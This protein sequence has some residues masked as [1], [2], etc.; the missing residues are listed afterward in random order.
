MVE[1]TKT[2]LVG[3]SK[4]ASASNNDSRGV[5]GNV[6]GEHG[7]EQNLRSFDHSPRQNASPHYI[8]P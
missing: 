1:K 7:I 2:I 4:H 3:T 6:W 5:P 8:K